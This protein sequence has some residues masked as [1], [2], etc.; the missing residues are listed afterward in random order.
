MVGSAMAAP[1]Q[2]AMKLAN[3]AIQLDTQNRHKDAYCEYL[4]SINF[5]SQAL[6]D[7]AVTQDGTEIVAAD[8][9]KMLKLAEQCLERAK[10]TATKLGKLE[11]KPAALEQ[12]RPTCKPGHRRVLSD[13]GQ[14]TSPFLPP[15]IFEKM[16]IADTQNTKKELT[17]MEEAS[18]LNQKLKATY[19]ARLARLNPSQAM[20][21]T[22]LTLSLQRQMM[23][24]LI[25]AK[26]RQDAL[27]RKVEERRL[28]L[29]EEAN[30]RF[31]SSACLTAEEQEQ[32][33]FYT[34]ILEYDQ[35]HD[36]PKNWKSKLKKN[37]N[38]L[39]LVVGLL[40]CILSCP[41][42]PV[43]KL[44]KK[45][46]YRI[47][48]KLYSIVSRANCSHNLVQKSPAHVA[49]IGKQHSMKAS[50][51]I[52]CM[53]SLQENNQMNNEKMKHSVSV[54]SLP[55]IEDYNANTDS[56]VQE[57]TQHINN[58]ETS[59][60][61]AV[62]KDGSFEDLE[63]FLPQF[64]GQPESLPNLSSQKPEEFPVLSLENDNLPQ[65][66]KDIVKDIH[67][68]IDR[69]LSLCI[70]SFETLNNAAAKDQCLAILEEAFFTPI[71]TLLFALFRKVYINREIAF[72]R[73]MAL[74]KNMKPCDIGVKSKLFP[75][76]SSPP[77]GCYPYEVA[78]MELKQISKF[79][80][81]QKKLECIVK[82]LRL[83][84]ECAEEYRNSNEP[85]TSHTS[86]AIGADD[87][88]PILSYVALKSNFPQLVSE[89]AALEEFIHEGY[90]IGEEGY[91]LTSMQS[92]IAFVESLHN[93]KG[94][95]SK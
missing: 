31:S 22:S 29:Q 9:Q 65:Q 68:S 81:P 30:R 79:C 36:W 70:L 14:A 7:E 26:A 59:T 38:D 69:L 50:H 10:S 49:S 13:G 3:V 93:N 80:Y 57:Q 46:Q 90:L 87:L 56:R 89:C 1:L 67:N 18:R 95:A 62:D 91:C 58:Q 17:P 32:R 42:H 12:H 92:A 86:A 88:L 27:Q 43:M 51:S 77:S 16:Q 48:N 23:E 25:I 85:S 75:S 55:L 83:I 8:A 82:A 73:S 63:Q 74:Y 44:L 53:Q 39:S 19:E 6:L 60:L 52:H 21:K 33:I 61:S 78:V 28:R 54:T 94:G 15:E 40:S 37:P 5:I 76:E 84:C 24:N 45:L 35:D 4:K 11:E 20:Q 2:N 71:W 64:Q 34:S 47:Y 72:E 66:L 41:E